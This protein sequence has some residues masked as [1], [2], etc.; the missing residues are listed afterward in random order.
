MSTRDVAGWQAEINEVK[1]RIELIVNRD[2]WEGMML[3]D[4]LD[5]ALAAMFNGVLTQGYNEAAEI[6]D[7]RQSDYPN[8]SI[9]RQALA[10]LASHLR[11][12]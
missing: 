1:H 6:A 7:L 3:G 2:G 4:V 8:H 9:A 12:L 11:T 10:L 5:G